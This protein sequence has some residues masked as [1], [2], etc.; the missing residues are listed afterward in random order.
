MA[1]Q[2]EFP[3]QQTHKKS[4]EMAVLGFSVVCIVFV[5]LMVMFVEG[6]SF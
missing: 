1:G 4:F 3:E 2:I 6:G 5:I